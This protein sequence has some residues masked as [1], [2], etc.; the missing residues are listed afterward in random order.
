MTRRRH[1]CDLGC[2]RPRKRWQRLC[3]PCF[4]A[5]P[6]AIRVPLLGAWADKRRADYRFWLGE[7]AKAIAARATQ[8]FT[9]IARLTG[10]RD[11]DM[12][13]AE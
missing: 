12:E 2:G 9:T 10:D 13:P 8:A 3:A 5:T 1:V 6:P 11:P 4:A 7:A